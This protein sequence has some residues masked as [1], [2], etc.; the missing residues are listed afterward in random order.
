[1]GFMHA[2]FSSLA[3]DYLF[4]PPEKP[5]Y[6][7]EEEEGSKKLKL[8]LSA[9]TYTK[10][11]WYKPELKPGMDVVKIRTERGNDIV[12]VYVKNP[13]ASLTVLYSH[14]NAVDLGNLMRLRGLTELSD[15]LG[16]NVLGYDYSGYGQS[17]GKP[18][19][20]NTYADIEAAYRYLVDKY[21]AKEEDV[22]L[23]GSSIG[24]GPTIDLATRLPRLRGVVLQSAIT[25]ALRLV[26][27][28]L[29]AAGLER[30]SYSFDIYKNLEKI[31]LVSCPVLVI[32]GT[33]DEL[34]HWWHGQ[35]L[36]YHSKY[37]YEP[38]W[39]Q[40]GKH[41]DLNKYPRF[42]KH[43]KKFVS[44]MEIEFPYRRASQS[45]DHDERSRAISE[46]EVRSIKS[47]DVDKSEEQASNVSGKIFR[48]V[49]LLNCFK[50]A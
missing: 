26:S 44:D 1:M 38:L 15:H 46:E 14:G 39:I 21:D 22:I 5:F 30:R 49:G 20:E 32:H 10:F 12:A 41:N 2:V 18:S 13:S 34:V 6:T 17:T 27:F 24:A 29:C 3:T 47:F 25:S 8:E 23:Y 28:A 40:G 48:S 45:I 7:L 16:V 9:V 33:A 43:L 42:R 35:Q 4:H 11:P 36:W 50:P 19:E 31:P 37:R